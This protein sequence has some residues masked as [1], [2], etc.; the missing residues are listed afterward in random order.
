MTDL[1]PVL[2]EPVREALRL[3]G[4]PAR[5]MR[6]RP[7]SGGCINNAARLDTGKMT[8]L[9]KWNPRPLPD[10][11]L[12]EV[13]G[14]NAM[15]ATGTV[16]V[17]EPYAASNAANGAPAFIL[18]EWLQAPKNAGRI[19]FALLGAQLAQMHRNGPAASLP[20]A[21]GLGMDNYL[22]PTRQENIWE[23]DW[24][25]FYRERRLRPQMELAQQ[26]GRMP[27]GRRRRLERLMN[28]LENWLGGVTRQPALIHGDLWSGNVMVGPGGAP[29]LIDP[30]VYYADREAELAYT[31]LFGGFDASFY[32]AYQESWPLEPGFRDRRDLYNLY[33]LLNHLNIFGESYGYQ[34]DAVLRRYVS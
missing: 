16:R 18:M 32:A 10:M 33:H 14:L 31:H 2:E 5:S 11:F 23:T 1:P 6:V 27:V 12:A 30:A 4:D 8:Y 9:L 17:P 21:Y 34:V 15:R 26:N 3:L 28:G 25:G 22:G 20:Q 29:A 24:V 13:E 19:D 7:V